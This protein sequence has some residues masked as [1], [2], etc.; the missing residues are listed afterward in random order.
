MTV[1]ES[2]LRSLFSLSRIAPPEDDVLTRFGDELNSLLRYVDVLESVD[3]S[4][5]EPFLHPGHERLRRRKDESAEVIGERA[6]RGAARIDNGQVSV[7][8]VVD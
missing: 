5:I 4:G 6:L 8:K 2:T 7:P 1:D 3:T